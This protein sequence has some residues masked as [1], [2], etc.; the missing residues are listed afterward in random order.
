MAEIFVSFFIL[1]IIGIFSKKPDHQ[2]DL[3]QIIPIIDILDDPKDKGCNNHDY[4]VSAGDEFYS[5]D[6]FDEFDL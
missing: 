1:F 4:S 3:D 6:D 2:K 5:E